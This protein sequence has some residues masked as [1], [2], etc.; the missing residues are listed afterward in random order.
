MRLL[1]CTPTTALSGGIKVIFELINRLHAQ[2]IECDLFSFAAGPSWF[3]LSARVLPQ[4]NLEDVD[5]S[6][7]DFVL[8]SNA[9]MVPMA[10]SHVRHPGL[11]FF[12]QD[13]ESFHHAHGLS[14]AECVQD[15]PAYSRIYRLPVPIIAVSKSI[16]HLIKERAGRDSYFMPLGIDK[17]LF[18][19]QP[20]RLPTLPYRILMV[21]NY[22]LPHKGMRDGFEALAI[23]SREHPVQLVLM[24]QASKGRE[25]LERCG[26]PVEIHFCCPPEKVPEVMATCDA[27]CC[28]SWYEGF[29]LPAVEAFHCGL[30]VVSTRTMGVSDYGVDGENLLLANPNDPDDLYQKLKQ[31]IT[32]PALQQRLIEAGFATVKDR[33]DWDT[34]ADA[35]LAAL[36]H[37]AS[38]KRG[39]TP[40][41]REE[42]KALLADLES[43]GSLTP[44]PVFREFQRLTRE[45]D[46]LC[47][48]AISRSAL[49]SADVDQLAALRD[50]FALYTSNPKAEYYDAFKQKYDL[51]RLVL[52]LR[53]SDRCS[54]YLELIQNRGR[55]DGRRDPSPLVEIRYTHA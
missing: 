36:N 27:Y 11:I 30:P 16:R 17:N 6:A 42:M 45:L 21:G 20:R 15:S 31:L 14:Y 32:D 48:G 4:K 33:Y 51:C 54:Q 43:A 35:F 2:G 26:C 10:L 52:S 39:P 53:D 40:V 12:C 37:T 49:S 46:T 23:L 47:S 7:Y 19:P 41:D 8:L 50:Q 3:P 22:L 5:L 38:A 25:V 28:T 1:F 44:I 29:G 24:T 55:G 34:S 9:F 18:R 13:Y